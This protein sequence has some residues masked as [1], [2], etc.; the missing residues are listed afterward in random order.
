MRSWYP[1]YWPGGQELMESLYRKRIQDAF[2]RVEKSF[3]NVDPDIAECEQAQGSLTITF[4]DGARCILSAQPSVRQLWLA[5]ASRG[6]AYHF[7][8]DEDSGKWVDDKG[9][10]VELISFLNGF[11]KEIT[12]IHFDI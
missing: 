4:S 2:D 1:Q 11:L 7:N 3:E 12:G 10:S 8:F 6:T 9:R 5:L